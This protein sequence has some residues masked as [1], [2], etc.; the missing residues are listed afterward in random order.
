M[1]K[2]G[3]AATAPELLA[4]ALI[5]DSGRFL[6]LESKPREGSETIGLPCALVKKGG[7]PVSAL[8]RAIIEQ[9]GIDAHVK[10][11]ALRGRFNLGSRKRKVWIPALAFNVSSKSYSARSSRDFSKAVWL[12]AEDAL[13]KRLSRTSDWLRN[14]ERVP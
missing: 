7:D 6:F 12:S 9:A 11:P 4:C 8:A 3:K 1:Q 10:E 14:C 13:K 5:E 2:T